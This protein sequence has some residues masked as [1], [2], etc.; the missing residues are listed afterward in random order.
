MKIVFLSSADNYHTKKWCNYFTSRNHEVHVISFTNDKIDNAVIHYID[1]GVGPQN[2]DIEKLNYLKSIKKVKKIIKELNP[3]IINAHY[4]SSYGMIASLA[5]PN[6]FILSIWG[7]DIYEFP[8][9]SIIHKIYIKYVLK[10]AK[11]LFSTSHAMA[12]VI[13]IYTRKKVYITPFGVDMDLFNPNKKEE[14]KEKKFIIGTIKALTPKYGIDILLRAAEIL[15][16]RKKIDLEV[17]IA[18][19]GECEQEYK[20]LSNDL[21]ISSITKWLGFISQENVAKEWANMDVA[22]IASMNE[23]ESFGVS[24]VEA[25]ACCIPVVISDIPGLMESTIP[26]QTSI[27]FPRGDYNILADT[28]ENLYYDVRKR[29]QLGKNGRK[30]VLENYEYNYCFDRIEKLFLEFNNKQYNK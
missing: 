21:G 27:V 4:A 10:K 22:I 8:K 23:S 9:K 11:Y 15:Y 25:E 3:D 5:C 29:K 12:K 17:R 18:G 14:R 26:N 19:K 16:K 2:T 7:A 1:C 6:K 24:A 13:N 20:K 30:Y 28:I